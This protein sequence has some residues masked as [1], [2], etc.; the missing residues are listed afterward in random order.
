[1][2]VLLFVA[3]TGFM[4]LIGLKEAAGNAPFTLSTSSI[5]WENFWLLINN[6]LQHAF[7]MK[8][9]D[10]VA[11]TN[12]GKFIQTLLT[13]VLLPIQAALFIIALRNKFRR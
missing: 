10:L 9:P 6:T 5:N 3:I 13:R 7:F 8:N 11:S 1:M 4:Y 12:F 2:F